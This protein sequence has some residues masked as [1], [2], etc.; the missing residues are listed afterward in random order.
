M[1]Q[2]RQYAYNLPWRG[3]V[4]GSLFYAGLF[5]LMVHLAK[6][7]AGVLFAGLVVLSA[8][9]V[10]L[11]VAMLARRLVFP[12]VLELTDDAVLF[13]HGFPRTRITR[14]PFTEIIRMSWTRT[15]LYMVTERGHFEI[16]S[17]HFKE[18]ESYRD[19]T[20]FVCAKTFFVMPRQDKQGPMD[21]MSG[22]FPEPILRWKEPIEWPRYRT[23]LVESRPLLP[24]LVKALWF[25]VRCF[26]IFLI[27]WLL[28]RLFRVPTA[29]AVGY[30]CLA[31]AGAFLI[32][33]FYQWLAN[34]WPVHCTEI[35][36][37]DN[38]ITQFFGKQTA[39][40]NYHQFSGWGIVEKEFEGRTF[41]ILL[42]QG[43]SRIVALAIPDTD[44]RDRLVQ[45][46]H[47]KKI[48][49]LPDLKPPWELRP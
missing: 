48:P 13:P 7:F 6:E 10:I 43:R 20:D 31:V 37:R 21:W 3:A 30:V 4:T 40:W 32:T 41:S 35:S 27:P 28:L 46:L 23:H 33:L 14:I 15:G 19:A 11:A 24:R 16:T 1:N 34:V 17:S 38:G 49:Q 45:I 29:P 36:F 39:D 12:R 26:A 5:V 25:F 44:I 9:F 8:M 2:S 47:D 42:L 22:G 18:I